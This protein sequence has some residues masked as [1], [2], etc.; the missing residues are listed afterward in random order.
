MAPQTIKNGI[1]IDKNC[2]WTLFSAMS[3]PRR[4]MGR[5]DGKRQVVLGGALFQIVV[6]RV[7]FGTSKIDKIDGQIDSEKLSKND[8]EIIRKW[9]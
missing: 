4:Q 6:Q 5:S 7:N 2:V 1:K 3:R 9:N 8:S